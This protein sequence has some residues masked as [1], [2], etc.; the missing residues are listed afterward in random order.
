MAIINSAVPNDASPGLKAWLADQF[1][2]IATYLRNPTPTTIT[3]AVLGVEPSNPTNGMIVYADGTKW[4]PGSGAGVYAR[5][6]GSWVK[7]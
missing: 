3:L 7:L 2:S 4:N 1:R 6:S 5:V